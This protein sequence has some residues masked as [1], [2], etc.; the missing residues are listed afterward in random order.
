MSRG[1]VPHQ[2]TAGLGTEVPSCVTHSLSVSQQAGGTQADRAAPDSVH[3]YSL[4][5]L[6]LPSFHAGDLL[7][8]RHLFQA[9][10]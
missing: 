8:Y 9:S 2:G 10:T 7:P 4:A 6:F 1:C 3:S 5:S